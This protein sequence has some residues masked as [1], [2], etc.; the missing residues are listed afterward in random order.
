MLFPFG[1]G[2]V[3]GDADD[4]SR[5]DRAEIIDFIDIHAAELGRTV[6]AAG[7]VAG[8]FEHTDALGF[9]VELCGCHLASSGVVVGDG[10]LCRYRCACLDEV[11]PLLAEIL[12]G[13]D[14]RFPRLSVG[15]IPLDVV[16]AVVVLVGQSS[17]G[18]S[19][20]LNV[21]FLHE[22][23]LCLYSF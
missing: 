22:F 12:Q 11:A 18:V 6:G 10:G 19:D 7:H 9:F 15:R 17:V 8:S 1:S 13:G 16:V 23:F 14:V 21:V 4:G 20:L 3:V 2:I 5:A